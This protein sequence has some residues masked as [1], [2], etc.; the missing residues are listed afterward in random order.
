MNQTQTFLFML[1]LFIITG[2]YGQTTWDLISQAEENLII[3]NQST[4][5]S[6]VNE[7]VGSHGEKYTLKKSSN[8]F[9]SYSSIRTEVGDFGCYPLDKTFCT[10]ADTLFINKL[11]QVPLGCYANHISKI[12]NFNPNNI[13]FKDLHF[14]KNEI[15]NK[16]IVVL[17]ES[18][19]GDG[20]TFEAKTRLIKFLIEEM[21]YSTLAFEGGGF[22][23]MT[24]AS[25]Q[26]SDGKNVF[27]EIN[28]SWF[29]LWSQS[30][31]TQNLLKYIE[32]NKNIKLLGIEN[33]LTNQYSLIL[34]EIIYSLVGETAFKGIDYEYFDNNLRDYY[35]STFSSDT[36]T[37]NQVDVL[38]LKN[39]LIKIKKNLE[40]I[41]SK[42]SKIVLQ[43][44]KNI[45]GYIAQLELNYGSYQDQNQSI[46]MRDSLMAENIIWYLNEHPDEKIIIWTANLHATRSTDKAIYKEN[47][48]FYQVFKSLTNRLIGKYGDDVY[49]AAFTSITGERA[50]VYQVEPQLIEI[51]KDSWNYKVASSISHPYAFVNFKEIRKNTDCANLI[52]N[53]TI[54]GYKSHVGD[55][56]SIFDG[57]FIIKE[58]YRSDPKE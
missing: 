56:F 14:L 46:S 13:D 11:C 26:I 10:D 42:N 50:N 58:M 34:A 29:S 55:W 44:V 51:P 43:G 54:L 12:D 36:L 47:D 3:T 9:Q 5:L 41:D 20:A 32:E 45:E 53:S 4:R 39:D 27:T 7:N 37:S 16:R 23:E 1:T 33:Q 25:N 17:G 21:N 40:K 35:V 8:A 48:D 49:A 19:H 52:F 31:Q 57:V 18:G 24:Y 22:I 15:K 38:K 30:K 28:N 6:Y 2:V